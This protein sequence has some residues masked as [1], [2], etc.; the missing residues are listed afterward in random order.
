M[1]NDKRSSPVIPS[2]HKVWLYANDVAEVR[3]TQLELLTLNVRATP[4]Q[5]SIEIVGLHAYQLAKEGNR[6]D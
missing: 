1:R 4:I 3:Y 5:V 2:L 6:F